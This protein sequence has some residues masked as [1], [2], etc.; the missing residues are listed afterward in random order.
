MCYDGDAVHHNN[1]GVYMDNKKFAF[2]LAEMMVVMLIMSIVLAAFAPVMTTRQKKDISSPWR[3]SDNQ[4]DAY[5][6]LGNDQRAMIGQKNRPSGGTDPDNRLTIATSRS[7]QSHILFK[8][9]NNNVQA[10]LFLGNSSIILGNDTSTSSNVISIGRGST[11]TADYAT[12]LGFRADATGE[13]SMALGSGTASGENSV[14]IGPYVTASEKNTLAISSGNAGEVAKATSLGALAIG[15]GTASGNYSLVLAPNHNGGGASSHSESS[16][17]CSIA[18]GGNT[19]SSG[20]YSVGMGTGVTVSNSDSIAL[21]SGASS[22]NENY[23]KATGGVAIGEGA[24]SID[25]G[26]SIGKDSITNTSVT[27][28]PN[29]SV[30]LG[31]DTS[32]VDGGIAIGSDAKAGGR[33]ATGIAIGQHADAMGTNTELGGG[34]A[35]GGSSKVENGAVAIGFSSVATPHTAYANNAAVAIGMDV[36]AQGSS[37]AV[38][39]R[40]QANS[41]G[42]AIGNYSMALGENNVAI[43]NSALQANT[44]GN[45]NVAIGYSIL[46]S[47]EGGSEN[48]AIGYEA[49][50][51]NKYGALNVGIGSRALY[52]IQG[53]KGDYLKASSNV[54]I[55]SSAQNRNISG[56]DNVAIGNQSLFNNESGIHNTAIGSYACQFV[57]GSNKTCLGYYSGPMGADENSNKTVY[58]GESGTTIIMAGSSTGYS[59]R[60]LKYV[61]NENK[62]GLEK[63]KQLKVFNYTFKKDEKKTPRVGIIAQDLMKV[64]PKAVTLNGDG[65]YIT[66]TEDILYALVNAVKELDAKISMIAAEYKAQLKILKQVQDDNRKILND[67][68]LLKQENKELRLRLE[69]LEARIK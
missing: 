18:I 25:G 65:F 44:E 62:D 67:N 20:S 8:D 16:S 52:Q 9:Q 1:T 46:T 51:H 64:F 38:G 6:G 41:S 37:V 29:S 50:N 12:A 57:K 55:G 14:A 30:S 13:L 3:F 24:T 7:T 58:I 68:K 35:I 40:V 39:A 26:I 48:V 28:Y 63:I 10:R 15:N 27:Y 47:N 61:G 54:A 22:K 45:G 66:R 23:S 59:D 49:L 31:R 11:A 34:I 33:F 32:S 56:Y 36:E 42:V 53:V 60:R 5:F 4:M 43:G 21:G 17:Y 69:K 19:H 2:T